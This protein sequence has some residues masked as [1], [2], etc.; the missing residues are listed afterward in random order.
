ME[1]TKETGAKAMLVKP[2][3]VKELAS[4]YGVSPR[5]FRN[6][7]APFKDEL[8][9]RTGH[10]Y[11]VDEVK[12]ILKKFG[13]P[14]GRVIENLPLH[15]DSTNETSKY[16][17]AAWLFAWAVLWDGKNISDEEIGY[18]QKHLHD[19]FTLKSTSGAEPCHEKHLSIFC[20]RI[21]LTRMYLDYKPGQFIPEP[22]IW[23]DKGYTYGFAG[24]RKWFLEIHEARKQNPLFREE[25]IQLAAFFREYIETKSIAVLNKAG[26]YFLKKGHT[27]LMKIFSGCISK[28]NTKS[29]Y[30]IAA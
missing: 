23:F 9:K 28:I 24:T 13:I 16:V 8:G 19:F 2:Y 10:F 18:S 12:A 7:I 11:M 22:A 4:L 14:K 21:T 5:T 15:D 26:D 29:N 20:Q 1:N 17:N 27:H 6:W 30:S 25:L 3:T